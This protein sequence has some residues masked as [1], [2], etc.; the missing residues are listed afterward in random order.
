MPQN[1]EAVSQFKILTKSSSDRGL[2]HI[3]AHHANFPADFL[4]TA[5][6]GVQL[7]LRSCGSGVGGAERN[8][9]R[10]IYAYLSKFN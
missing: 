5:I 9:A 7:I 10:P 1:L 6:C 2:W 8:A 4:A 3:A